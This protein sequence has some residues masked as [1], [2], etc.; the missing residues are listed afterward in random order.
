MLCIMQ[1]SIKDL[2]SSDAFMTNWMLL[3]LI[4]QG[5]I[6]V[7][8]LHYSVN[9]QMEEEERSLRWWSLKACSSL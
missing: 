8:T 3:M 4:A 7:S 1:I 6:I 9:E 5:Y 2:I